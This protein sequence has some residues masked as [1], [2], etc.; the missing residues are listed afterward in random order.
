MRQG[1]H[2]FKF[3]FIFRRRSDF[4]YLAV[5]K[6]HDLMTVLLCGAGKLEAVGGRLDGI[7]KP[8]PYRSILFIRGV[9]FQDRLENV[10]V[11]GVAAVQ[12]EVDL[13]RIVKLAQLPLALLILGGK[14][15]F[16]CRFRPRRTKSPTARDNGC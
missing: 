8:F 11:G 12:V 7:G 2:F 14:R 6:E 10:D 9:L 16:R 1:A 15:L 4:L 3:C 13:F 5:A